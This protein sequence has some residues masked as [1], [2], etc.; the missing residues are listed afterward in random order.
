MM[1]E[2]VPLTSNQ[3]QWL[4]KV[5]SEKDKN[6]QMMSTGY[7]YIPMT[8][9]ALQGATITGSRLVHIEPIDSCQSTLT[10]ILVQ[11]LFLFTNFTRSD[12]YTMY[13]IYRICYQARNIMC[14]EGCGHHI[15]ET[16]SSHH[17]VT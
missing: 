13:I 11:E 14:I 17:R 6:K 16:R 4:H 3:V 9:L 12:L 5:Q 10:V 7:L 2:P 8:V 15:S 1:I